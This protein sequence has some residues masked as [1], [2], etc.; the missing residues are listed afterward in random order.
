MTGEDDV[1]EMLWDCQYCG[2]KKL[3]AKTQRFC[4]SCGGAQVAKWRYFPA[5]EEKIAVKDHIYVGVDRMC[6]ACGVANARIAKH[7]ISCGSP[8]DEAKDAEQRHQQAHAEGVAFT[9]ETVAAA[10]Q[11]L[12]AAHTN[13]IS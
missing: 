9:S 10:K 8:L 11:E 2:T 6:P 5:D 3:L 4:P 1:Y 7:C 12:A 13:A